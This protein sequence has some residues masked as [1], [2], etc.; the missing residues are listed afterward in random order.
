MSLMTLLSR[1][2]AKLPPKLDYCSKEDCV[3]IASHPYRDIDL[4][5]DHWMEEIDRY[6]VEKAIEK[7]WESN[8]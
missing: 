3:G 8:R 5:Y 7:A 2:S 6:R 1:Q 4:C